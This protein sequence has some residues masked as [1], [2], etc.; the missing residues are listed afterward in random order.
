MGPM[1]NRPASHVRDMRQDDALAVATVHVNAWKVAYRGGL[2][3]DAYLDALT[4][5]DRVASWT[6]TLSRPAPPAAMRLVSEADGS[7]CGFVVAGREGGSTTS[8]DA[9]EVY[10]L[11]VDPAYWGGGHGLA[12]L[13]EAHRRLLGS[14]FPSAVLWVHPDNTRARRFYECL[15]WRC[16]GT[17]RTQEVHG[18]EVPEVRYQRDLAE[19]R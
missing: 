16:E 15:G 5:D 9:G 6:T 14:G 8:N 18:V 13:T 2:M 10:A 1:M 12:L 19:E 4:V 11:N 17:L 7:V 3:P